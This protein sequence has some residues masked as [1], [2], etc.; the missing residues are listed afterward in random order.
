MATELRRGRG[1]S[2]DTPLQL[3]RTS[4]IWNPNYHKVFAFQ[5]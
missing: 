1:A 4:W 5:K 2:A 3:L